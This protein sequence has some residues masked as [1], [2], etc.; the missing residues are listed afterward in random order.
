LL[1]DVY[2][3]RQA[4]TVGEREGGRKGVSKNR[5]ELGKLKQI[6]GDMKS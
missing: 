4:F 5:D 6:V 1:S 3:L 2:S